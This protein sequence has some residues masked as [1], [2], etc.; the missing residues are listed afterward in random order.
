[1]AAS[2]TPRRRSDDLVRRLPGATRPPGPQR[3]P[4]LIVGGGVGGLATAIRLRAAGHPVA[5]FERNDVAGGK[6]AVRERDGFVFDVG[7]SLVT[8]PSLFDDLCRLAGTTLDAELDLVRL[9]PQ[10]RYQWAD[11]SVRTMPDTGWDD[12][13]YRRF[14]ERGRRIWEVTER[15]FFAGPMS[16]AWSLV[17]RMRSPSDL[18]AID[19]F[20]TLTRRAE[21]TFDD[22]RLRQWA[23]RYATYSGSSPFRSPATLACIAA[24]EHDHG[25][26]YPIGG[27]GALR[28]LLIRLAERLGVELHCDAEVTTVLAERRGRG[29]VRGVVLADGHRFTAP[30][31]VVNA[32]ASHLYRDLFPNRRRRTR[33]DATPLSTSGLVVL[34][35]VAGRTPDLAHHNIWFSADSRREFDEIAGGALPGDPTIYACVSSVTD[36][37]Q[38]PDGDENW[39]LLV[40]TPPGIDLDPALA[41]EVVLG[42]LAAHGTDLRPRLRFTETI[43]PRDLEHRYRAPGGAI[44]GTSSDG[45]RAAFR[46]PNNRGPVR[47]LYLVG[48][49]SHPGGGLPLVTISA[50]I[51]ADLVAADVA[52]GVVA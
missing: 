48:G 44:Y 4:A 28:D 12:A 49:S 41:T 40:N 11:G 25:C 6:L 31:V 3:P 43:T 5:V 22:P 45:M 9:D 18:T 32:D 16:G 19:P 8:L 30:I 21:R 35:G 39:F 15:T 37:S 10:F 34:A 29:G 17:R 46:R 24:L 42:R 23:G 13:D 1:M 27:L 26:W 7:P 50:R 51:V 14:V 47:G 52:R 2:G 36:P 38:A 20:R 33:I